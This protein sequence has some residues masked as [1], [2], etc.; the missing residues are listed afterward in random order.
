M[1]D[2][3]LQLQMTLASAS[4]PNCELLFDISRYFSIDSIGEVC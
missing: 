1:N 3:I 4:F 2:I